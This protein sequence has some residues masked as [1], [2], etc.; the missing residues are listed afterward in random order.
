M[1]T[2]RLDAD[3]RAVQLPVR[4]LL[5]P[6]GGVDQARQGQGGRD[7][8]CHQQARSG[9]QPCLD[10]AAPGRQPQGRYTNN[11]KKLLM[12]GPLTAAEF[13]EITGWPD[14]AAR[15][16]LQWLHQ[17]EVLTVINEGGKRKYQLA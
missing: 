7:A 10:L 8:G 3:M 6:A 11:A 5:R 1:H 4:G 13:I 2:S 17:Q 14:K 9:A 16:T 12:H 15:R